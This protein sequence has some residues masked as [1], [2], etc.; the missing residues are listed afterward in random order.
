ME[1]IW[2]AWFPVWTASGF[3]WLKNVKVYETEKYYDIPFTFF[4]E[5]GVIS[6]VRVSKRYEK[7]K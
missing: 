5:F 4:D 2:F 1:Y 6:I 3:A 7:I